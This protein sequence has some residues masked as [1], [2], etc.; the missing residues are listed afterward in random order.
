VI[1]PARKDPQVHRRSLNWLKRCREKGLPIFGQTA[2]I[3]TG[4]AFTLENWNLYDA[5][6]AWRAVTTGTTAEKIAKM[7]DPALRGAIKR[8]HE[9]ANRR[10]EVIQAGVGGKIRYLIV[11][12]AD[13]RPEL[14]KY[15]GKSVG[16][17]AAEEGK[18][19]ID[20]MLDL[21]VAGD[22][23][24]EF[25]GPNRGFQADYF[26]EMT[27][28]SP[29]T[30]PGVSDGGAHTKFFTGGAYTTDYLSWLVR[31][32]QKVT[33]EEAHYRLSALPAHAAGFRDRGVL[34]E[35]AW[36]DV[37]VY[38][39]K[40]LAITPEWVGEIVHDFPGGEWRRIQRA[41]GYRSIIVNG[42]VTFDEGRASG[43]TP[44]RLLRYG[45]A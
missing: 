32:E 43:E 29:Y 5:S 15:I 10:L 11:S 3:R 7:K 41:E 12:W 40:N 39:L 36:A 28:D 4:F 30:I 26:A 20:V 24:V 18:H 6:E 27:N 17:I 1:T 34:R 13:D 45:I 22:L 31:D 25:L 19:E 14:E 9:E 35:G 21:S 23:K 8:E 42:K 37:V 2:T 44:G 38:D 33:L 16:Q